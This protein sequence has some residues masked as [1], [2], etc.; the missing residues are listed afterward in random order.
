MKT[1]HRFFQSVPAGLRKAFTLI[2]L[3][4]V[5]AIIAILASMLLPALSQAKDKGHRTICLNNMKQILLSTFLY[6]DDWKDHLPY[7]GWGGTGQ[8]QRKNWAYEYSPRAQPEYLKK[9]D[10]PKSQRLI[11]G[12]QLFKYHETRKL[13]LCPI[14]FTNNALYQAR[15]VKNLSYCMN[16]SGSDYSSG[17][18][19]VGGNTFKSTMFDANDVMYWEQDETTPFWYND[20]SN[21]P[22]EGISSRHGIGALIGN[23]SGSS[24]WMSIPEYERLAGPIG[25]NNGQGMRPGRFWNSPGSATGD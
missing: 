12:G 20:A 16:G 18:G 22:D 4:V 11:R 13:L 5:I 1:Q 21:R 3:L 10:G 7:P 24:E 15:D 17:V 19:G 2:E 14:D 23:V 25:N 8:G 6:G 9:P